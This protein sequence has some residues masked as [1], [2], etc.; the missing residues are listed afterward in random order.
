MGRL[1]FPAVLVLAGGLS[2]LPARWSGW[3]GQLSRLVV[4]PTG[5]LS[6]WVLGMSRSVL[7]P[8]EPARAEELKLLEEQKQAFE[9]LYLRELAEIQRLRDIIRELQQGVALNPDA[10]VRQVMSPVIGTSADL[11][12]GLLSVRTGPSL[13]TDRTT[14][15]TTSGLQLV[16]R[17]T[18]SSGPT[19]WVMPITRRSAGKIQVAIMTD[20]GPAHLGSSLT[21]IGDGTLKGDVRRLDN[22]AASNET[23]AATSIPAVGQIVRLDDIDWPPSSRMLIVGR[24]VSV[25]PS[26]ED[27]LRSVIVVKPAMNIERLSEVLLRVQDPVSTPQASQG[28]KP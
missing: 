5:P 2:F 11:A 23:N 9:T 10:R 16:G 4:I 21:P 25:S 13:A 6:G 8:P 24:I 12:S 7:S 22:G 17:V 18:S 1:L 15:A 27:P 26:P 20:D 3:V 19:C 14:V 28:G